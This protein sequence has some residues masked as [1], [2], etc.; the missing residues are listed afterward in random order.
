MDVKRGRRVCASQIELYIRF[1]KKDDYTIVNKTV[2]YCMRLLNFMKYSRLKVL[3]DLKESRTG[4][5][6]NLIFKLK[7]IR[8]VY[9]HLLNFRDKLANRFIL[10]PVI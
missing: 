2:N 3:T 8:Y 5:D 4:N 7:H 1:F 6:K 10:K 9:N